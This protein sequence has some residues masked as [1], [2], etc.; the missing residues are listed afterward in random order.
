MEEA[1]LATFQNYIIDLEFLNVVEFSRFDPNGNYPGMSVGQ[2]THADNADNAANAQNAENAQNAQNAVHAENADSATTATHADA[3]DV[4]ASANS[5]EWGNVANKPTTLSG[6]GITD[7]YNKSESDQRYAPI[8]LA[9]ESGDIISV[10]DGANG[11]KAQI[12]PESDTTIW[13]TGVNVWDGETE[14]GSLR[15][16]NGQPTSGTTSVRSVN[17]I[18]VKPN[19][20]YTISNSSGYN[21]RYFTYKADK[22]FI[23][24]SNNFL[25]NITITTPANCYYLK[26]LIGTTAYNDD[27][28]LNYPATDTVYH[29]YSGV[30]VAGSAGIPAEL[31]TLYGKNTMW[32]EDG[33]VEAVYPADTKLYID[34]NINAIMAIIANL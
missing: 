26:L 14:E 29:P 25:T 6:Y 33:D 22:S 23:A 9:N 11:V 21:T 7:A 15:A 4:A 10:S 12:T 31:P 3:A 8:I 24:R 27:M 1:Y 2:A 30:S 16:D 28:S 19:T 13:R 32:A 34:K 20:T 17:Y 18:S 5:V